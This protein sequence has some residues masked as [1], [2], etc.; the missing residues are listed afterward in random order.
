MAESVTWGVEIVKI[1]MPACL[2]ALADVDADQYWR[3][4]NDAE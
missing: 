3:E 1:D 4:F 2:S